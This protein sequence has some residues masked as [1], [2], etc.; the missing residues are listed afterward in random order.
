MGAGCSSGVAVQR[1]RPGRVPPRSGSRPEK[2]YILSPRAFSE[3][4]LPIDT[5]QLSADRSRVSLEQCGGGGNTPTASHRKSLDS[6][7]TPPNRSSPPP[8]NSV[9]V[10]LSRRRC[11]GGMAPAPWGDIADGT[12]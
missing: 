6:H 1:P 3:T 8:W 11:V 5:P 9:P 4:D 2:A 10:A 12:E 7:S